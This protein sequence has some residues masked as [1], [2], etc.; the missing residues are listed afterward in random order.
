MAI[1]VQP[2]LA[3]LVEPVT[4]RVVDEEEHLAT[5]VASN[6]LPQELQRPWCH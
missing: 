6:E 5:V 3:L 4:G 2:A 1:R